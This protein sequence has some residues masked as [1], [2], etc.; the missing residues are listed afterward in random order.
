MTANAGLADVSA[1]VG[2]YPASGTKDI[3]RAS[4]EIRARQ[5]LSGPVQGVGQIASEKSS[6]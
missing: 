1:R 2:A 3:P 5:G 4:F 6:V